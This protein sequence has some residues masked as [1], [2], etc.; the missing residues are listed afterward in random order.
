MQKV[1]NQE[2]TLIYVACAGAQDA[3]GPSPK[4][5]AF[6]K[7]H[8]LTMYVTPSSCT[9]ILWKEDRVF[10]ND[11]VFNLGTKIFLQQVEHG[12][13]LLLY[14]LMPFVNSA[15]PTRCALEIAIGR[16]SARCL[17]VSIVAGITHARPSAG[18]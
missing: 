2:D 14:T 8:R 5:L 18:F 9:L 3:S 12:R 10:G 17:D 13:A 11:G 16:R 7:D 6:D 4:V 1:A 15:N